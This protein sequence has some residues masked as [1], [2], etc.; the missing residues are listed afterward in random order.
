MIALE[1]FVVKLVILR[2]SDVHFLHYGC[3]SPC[4][5]LMSEPLFLCVSEP[6][7]LCV[8]EPLCLVHSSYCTAIITLSH[9]CATNR[10]FTLIK[11]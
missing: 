6:L 1:L 8:S 3:P 9:L 5:L 10:C 11:P 7:L 4:V 2:C